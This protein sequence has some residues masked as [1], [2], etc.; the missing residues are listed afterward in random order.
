MRRERL[1]GGQE[2]RRKEGTLSLSP[3]ADQ[4]IAVVLSDVCGRANSPREVWF[5]VNRDTRFGVYLSVM[6]RTSHRRY[7]A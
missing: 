1:P 7:I 6:A 5:D 4:G 3:T 2:L